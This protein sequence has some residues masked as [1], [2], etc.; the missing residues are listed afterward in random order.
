MKSS[1][2]IPCL[3]YTF[4]EKCKEAVEYIRLSS[5]NQVGV[6]APREFCHWP[7]LFASPQRKQVAQQV[8]LRSDPRSQE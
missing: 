4:T 7:A 5:V 6:G 8:S 1:I 2:F 3:W